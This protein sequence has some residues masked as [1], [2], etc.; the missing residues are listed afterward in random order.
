MK[1][2]F[3]NN[4]DEKNYNDYYDEILD[5]FE[6]PNTR[7]TVS[8]SFGNTHVLK[9]GDSTKKPLL[10]LH[11]M[12]MSSV[13]WYPNVKYLIEEYCVFTV[14]VIGDYGRSDKVLKILN[15]KQ[16]AAEWLLEVV[17]G[18]S[19]KNFYLA[20]HSMGGFLALNFTLR[21][22]QLVEKLILLAPAATFQRLPII[23]FIKIFPPLIFRSRKLTD[24]ALKW[25]TIDTH[26]IPPAYRELMMIAYT[27]GVPLIQLVP[28]V[29][30]EEELQNLQTPTLLLI[31]DKEVIY[32]ST[33]AMTKA[34]KLIPNLQSY[35]IPN[36][37]HAFTI[38]QAN[39]VNTH[40][41]NFSRE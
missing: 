3:K 30:K 20:G 17:K 24:K 18:L 31:G 38:E 4:A 23:F 11:G 15:T 7:I 16:A 9:F 41:L 14:D 26:S 10:L 34:R 2:I 21:Y 28:S 6:V 27:K 12:T 35:L 29:F 5:K 36:A 13:M 25:I 40:I 37:N 8:T 39:L 19:L 33:K 32:S 1:S 22:S